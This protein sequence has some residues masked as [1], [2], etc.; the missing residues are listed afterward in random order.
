MPEQAR[1]WDSESARQ[2]QEQAASRVH[3][4]AACQVE[5]LPGNLPGESLRH[6]LHLQAGRERQE[7]R[8][9]AA[10]AAAPL[11][12]GKRE[13]ERL[14]GAVQEQAWPGQANFAH[15][16]SATELQRSAGFHKK[17]L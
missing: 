3:P 14:P 4:E 1:V 16:V 2:V 5:N 15:G 7:G 17:Q 10:V 8:E 13:W 6:P 12:P 11:H 9:S